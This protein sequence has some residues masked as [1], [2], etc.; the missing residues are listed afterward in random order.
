MPSEDPHIIATDGRMLCLLALPGK[1][2]VTPLNNDQGR[3]DVQQPPVWSRLLD[4][5]I[6]QNVHALIDAGE[7]PLPSHHVLYCTSIV[8]T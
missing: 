3:S 7:L 4:R 2:T 8:I 5:A 1:C 6:K